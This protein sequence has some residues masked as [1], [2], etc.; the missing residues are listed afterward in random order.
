MRM[1]VAKESEEYMKVYKIYDEDY[2][3]LAGEIQLG[4]FVAREVC[5]NSDSYEAEVLEEEGYASKE[6][7]KIRSLVEIIESGGHT[8]KVKEVE[9]LLK[10]RG[11]NLEEI[12]L[13]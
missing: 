4:D 9:L 6:I 5:D 8:T 1:W 7:K 2:E 10:V 12:E 11:Y 3:E 13:Y